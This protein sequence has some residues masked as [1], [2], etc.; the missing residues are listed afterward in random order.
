MREYQYVYTRSP[1]A[2]SKSNHEPLKQW[3]FPRLRS[4]EFCVVC[5]FFVGNIACSFSWK[6]NIKTCQEASHEART[7]P[8]HDFASLE[9]TSNTELNEKLM[10]IL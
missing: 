10:V 1:N 5:L 3:T 7:N 4:P 9:H 8:K 2:N 6:Q